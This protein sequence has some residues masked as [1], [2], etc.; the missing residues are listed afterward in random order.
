MEWA[1]HKR[2]SLLVT[3]ELNFRDK[4]LTVSALTADRH[5]PT[6]IMEVRGLEVDNGAKSNL[7][8]EE[9]SKDQKESDI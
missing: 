9:I 4:S 8:G 2:Y 3:Q 1:G 7:V 6:D 5:P